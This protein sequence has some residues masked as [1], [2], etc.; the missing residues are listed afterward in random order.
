MTQGNTRHARL[1]G[2]FCATFL[3]WSVALTAQTQLHNMASAF[4]RGSVRCCL[5]SKGAL[6]PSVQPM[7]TW[8]R[9]DTLKPQEQGFEGLLVLGEVRQMFGDLMAG[10]PAS[11]WGVAAR[12]G[13]GGYHVLRRGGACRSD[14]PGQRSGRPWIDGRLDAPFS[15]TN[16][17]QAS[18]AWKVPC[19]GP[20]PRPWCFVWS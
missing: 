8:N 16:P 3:V 9:P 7:T 12:L 20:C 11:G 17:W 10:A 2:L 1:Y 18:I 6:T 4:G 14:S 5:A 19:P 15:S 13:C